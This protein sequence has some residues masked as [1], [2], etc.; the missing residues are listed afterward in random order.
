MIMNKNE[1]ARTIKK[2]LNEIFRKTLK[3]SVTSKYR[4]N[5]PEITIHVKEAHENY[6]KTFNEYKQE[7][8]YLLLFHDHEV[9]EEILSQFTGHDITALKEDVKRT[10]M[11]TAGQYM[12]KKAPTDKEELQYSIILTDDGNPITKTQ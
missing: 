5:L 8:E 10:I 12:G 3:I 1:L 4:G 2:D 7:K 6:F 11:G 9:Y